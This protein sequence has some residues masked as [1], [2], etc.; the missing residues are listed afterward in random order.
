MDESKSFDVNFFK[1]STPFL[2]E[3]IRAIVIGLVIWGVATYGF[4]ILLKIMETPTSEAIYLS[5]QQAAPKLA[6]GSASPEDKVT[7]A[8][9]YLSMLGKSTALL[10]NDALKDAFTSTVYSLLSDAEKKT[11]LS[12]AQTA[13]TDK[14]V[15]VDFINTALGIT[16]NKAMMAAVPYSLSAVSPDK[17]AMTNDALTPLMDKFFIHNQSVL[18]DTIVFG[19][20]FHYLY[21]ALFLLTL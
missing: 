15:N 17:M 5:F 8:N 9:F 21:T 2:R 13:A 11:L 18:T 20:P 3:N 7:A 16:D 4:Q 12:V 19:F 6:D 1:P 10:N 14:K